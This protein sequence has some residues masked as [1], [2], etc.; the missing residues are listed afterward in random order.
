ML[1]CIKHKT[2]SKEPGDILRCFLCYRISF[3]KMVAT[4]HQIGFILIMGHDPTTWK[5]LTIWLRILSIYI[6]ICLGYSFPFVYSFWP[7]LKDHFLKEIFLD[8]QYPCKYHHQRRMESPLRCILA[9][10]TFHH[11]TYQ[12]SNRL[13][14]F[15]SLDYNLKGSRI[16]FANHV[17]SAHSTVPGIGGMICSK[18]FAE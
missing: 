17:F 16:Q 15:S 7:Q 8:H 1:E 14:I 10:Y 11:C 12:S 18:L 6:S 5:T 13:F 4:A 2:D 3:F 9:S